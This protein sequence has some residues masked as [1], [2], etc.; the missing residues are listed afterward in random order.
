MFKNTVIP[1]NPT[2]NGVTKKRHISILTREQNEQ[3]EEH[4]CFQLYNMLVR[5]FAC[6]SFCLFYTFF[7]ANDTGWLC[8]F[9]AAKCSS[10]NQLCKKVSK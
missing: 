10:I 3:I 9:L 6:L 5:L 1:A 8:L 4:F 7:A 2:S